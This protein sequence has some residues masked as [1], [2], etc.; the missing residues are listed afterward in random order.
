MILP[1]A[2][3]ASV[4][5]SALD[6]SRELTRSLIAID[7]CGKLETAFNETAAKF[8]VLPGAPYMAYVNCDD[9]PILCSSWAAGA[10]LAWAI[11]ML[12]APGAEINIYRHRFNVTT[13]TSDDMVALRT[14]N[15]DAS[16]QWHKV[17]SWFHPFNGKATELGLSVPFGY[18][19]WFFNLVPSWLFML[20][21]SFAS[22]SMM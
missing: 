17:E 22:R 8:A 7:R 4:G 11:D 13:V 9:Q 18:T 10:G 16:Q 6:P 5:T 2:P 3:A 21:V 20:L 12:P 14:D 19:L 1:C 15:K